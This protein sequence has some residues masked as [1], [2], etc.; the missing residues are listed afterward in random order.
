M[1]TGERAARIEAAALSN[2]AFKKGALPKPKFFPDEAL[3]KEVRAL[4][5]DRP[6]RG[7]DDW[8]HPHTFGRWCRRREI[9][10]VLAQGLDLELTRTR[11]APTLGLIFEAGH[12]THRHYRN[13]LI[14]HKL[15]GCWKCG[16]CGEPH[17]YHIHTQENGWTDLIVDNLITRPEACQQCGFTEKRSFRQGY[18][19]YME[20]IEPPIVIEGYKIKGHTDGILL[21]LGK[22]L[23]GEFKS[24]D[25]MLWT[26]R[27]G[28]NPGHTFQGACYAWGMKETYG[29]DIPLTAAV[30]INKS[31]YRPKTYIFRNDDKIDWIKQEI[32]AVNAIASAFTSKVSSE[33]D[34]RAIE[35][36]PELNAR[37]IKPCAHAGL[38]QAK[39]CPLREICFDLKSRKKKGT[40]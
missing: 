31:T 32:D 9:L 3:D 39:G 20:F 27:R 5:S 15:R 29:L 21:H 18:E 26:E 33:T 19:V 10:R 11:P 13:V 22:E 2:I 8:F 16:A 12:A 17:G 36:D 24:E 7:V 14:P 25:P 30:Y 35:M 38:S 37:A 6:H 28:P 34:L 23:I 40:K 1:D 4:L